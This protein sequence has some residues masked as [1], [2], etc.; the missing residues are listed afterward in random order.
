MR[1]SL[2][3]QRVDAIFSISS[4][5]QSQS[6]RILVALHAIEQLAQAFVTNIMSRVAH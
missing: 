5:A 4:V 2:S 6:A 1:F 3:S